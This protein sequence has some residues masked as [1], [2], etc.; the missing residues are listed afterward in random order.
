AAPAPRGP[1]PCFGGAGPDKV[2]CTGCGACMTG[3]R[4]GAKN[5]LDRNYL[6]LAEHNGAA[7]HPD[8]QVV[9]L[10]PIEGGGWLVHTDR[11]GAVLRRRRRT[12]LARDVVFSAGVLGTLK[13]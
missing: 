11:S 7:V 9:D 5:T 12:F 13:L 10:A 1:D 6:Y 3:C 8:T 2:G 4:V